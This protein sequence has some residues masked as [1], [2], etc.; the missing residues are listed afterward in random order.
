MKSGYL[1]IVKKGIRICFWGDM[2]NDLI[3]YFILFL[4]IEIEID[5]WNLWNKLEYF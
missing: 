1:N 4:F 2:I 3:I 5:E